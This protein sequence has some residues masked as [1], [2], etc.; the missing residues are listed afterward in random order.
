MPY[1]WQDRPDGGK[2]LTLW[3]YRSLPKRGFVV[4][5]ALTAAMISLPLF[6]LLGSATLWV[7]LPFLMLAV[8]AIWWALARSYRDGQLQERLVL[9]GD[10]VRLD[11]HAPDGS[12]QDWQANPYWT[13]IAIHPKGGPVEDYLTLKGNGRE[14]EIG[15]F[16]TPAERRRLY[17]ELRPLFGARL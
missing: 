6:A 4:F 8:A 1:E 5:I 7:I 13:K 14:V 15:A 11:R 3:P 17:G 16:L 10:V 2:E 12:V 9:A